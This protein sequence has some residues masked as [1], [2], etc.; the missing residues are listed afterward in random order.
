LG[1]NQLRITGR[2]AAFHDGRLTV[3]AS[4][5]SVPPPPGSDVR[6]FRFTDRTV[7]TER[8]ARWI[9]LGSAQVIRYDNGVMHLGLDEV[10]PIPGVDDPL[11][12]GTAV[13]L[14]WTR[15]DTPATP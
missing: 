4:P 2:V 3:T 7:G 1:A 13:R 12:F 10:T 15:A 5:D 9:E 11:A 6:V 14:V 8:S